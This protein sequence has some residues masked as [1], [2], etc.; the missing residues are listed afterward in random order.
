MSHPSRVR[1]AANLAAPRAPY[2]PPGAPRVAWLTWLRDVDP[3]GVYSDADCI[4]E[5][6]AP[7]TYFEAVEAAA[8]ILENI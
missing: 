1:R 3:N 4:A 6:G 8:L 7:L 5:F 2:I